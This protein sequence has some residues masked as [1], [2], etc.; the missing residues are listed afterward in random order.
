MWASL[1]G[2]LDPDTGVMEEYKLPPSSRH[3]VVPDKQGN[4]WYTG[5]SNATVG[6]LNPAT[7][8]VTEYKTEAVTSFSG[9]SSEWQ[10]V[11]YCAGAAMLGRLDPNTGDLTE[12]PVEPRPYGIKVDSQGTVWV[13]FNGTNKIGALDPDSMAIRYYEVPDE[14]TESA[15]WIWTV[16][17][18]SGLSIPRWARSG[19]LTRNWPDYPVGFTQRTEISPLF[20]GGD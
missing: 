1:T 11:L 17:T 9:F 8:E 7:G 16:R 14:R 10:L 6:K 19:S 2:R 3:T 5:N 4:I 18:S 12:I 13:A 15:V 20:H